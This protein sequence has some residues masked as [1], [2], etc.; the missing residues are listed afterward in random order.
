MKSLERT[1]RLAGFLYLLVTLA[2]PF[3]LLYVPG[4]ILVPGDATATIKRILDHES[5]FQAG[6]VVGFVSQLLF[7]FLVLTLYRLFEGVNRRLAV[8]MVVLILLDAPLAFLGLANEVATLGIARGADFLAVFDEPQRDALAM[9]LL[10]ADRAGTLVS[11][12]FWGLWLFPLGILVHRSGF[13]PRLIGLWL[14]ANGIAYVA[15]SVTGLYYPAY[16]QDLLVY[17]TPI[18]FGEVALM[19]WLLIVGVRTRAPAPLE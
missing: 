14:I 13:V 18:L 12:V 10:E 9:L 7:V 4:K 17:A 2:G 16:R 15:L 1:A 11:Q 19:L 8:A 3:V 5:L 6:I